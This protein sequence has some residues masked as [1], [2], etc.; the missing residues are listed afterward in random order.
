LQFEIKSQ[1]SDV[2][3]RPFWL[4]VASRIST[5]IRDRERKNQQR[6]ENWNTGH[7]DASQVNSMPGH[8]VPD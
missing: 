7:V 8:N 6:H 5:S 2:L 3:G 4:A 1:I